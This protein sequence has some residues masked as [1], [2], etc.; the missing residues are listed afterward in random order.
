MKTC[1]ATLPLMQRSNSQPAG[2]RGRGQAMWRWE[3][4]RFRTSGLAALTLMCVV[5]AFGSTLSHEFPARFSGEL[6]LIRHTPH[7]TLV[8][9]RLC[10]APA[11]LSLWGLGNYIVKWST[12]VFWRM[13]LSRQDSTKTATN[14]DPVEVLGIDQRANFE[15]IKRVPCSDAT[16]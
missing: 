16:W 8:H 3:L 6:L 12:G 14:F 10:R 4:N 13:H 2:P 11:G 7:I 15:E 9:F 1:S 5:S